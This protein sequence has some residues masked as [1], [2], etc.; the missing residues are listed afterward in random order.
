MMRPKRLAYRML[1]NPEMMARFER[2]DARDRYGNL[3]YLEALRLFEAMWAHAAEIDPGFAERNL[4]AVPE[5][6]FAV[7]R[8]IN[9][10]PPRA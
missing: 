10:L 2:D 3:S 7:A 4:E 1:K 8:A 9:G 6:A 5:G